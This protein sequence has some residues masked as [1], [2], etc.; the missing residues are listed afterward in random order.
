MHNTTMLAIRPPPRFKERKECAMRDLHKIRKLW[1][2][3]KDA[4]NDLIR[5]DC[6]E[7]HVIFEG[8]AEQCFLL[9]AHLSKASREA[10]AKLS[11]R[12]AELLDMH[13]LIA[14]RAGETR[15]TVQLILEGANVNSYS[16]VRDTAGHVAAAHG[17]EGCLKILIG[18]GF[19]VNRVNSWLDTA[20]HYAAANGY[21]TCLKMLIAAGL[22]VNIK[23]LVWETAGHTAAR[24]EQEE[25]L[26]ILINSG[27]QVNRELRKLA[28]EHGIKLPKH[29]LYERIIKRLLHFISWHPSH[30]QDQ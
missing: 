21:I 25:C 4:T 17:S 20:G 26:K 2:I 8:K 27:L 22:D 5:K 12:E 9:G 19:D 18:A 24:K 7:A 28:R 11:D 29:P 1:H 14:C 13:L 3:L 16:R 30:A 10:R 6:E 15:E 23:N